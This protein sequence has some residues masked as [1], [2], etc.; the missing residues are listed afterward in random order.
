MGRRLRDAA[1]LL[2]VKVLGE[3]PAHVV[4]RWRDAERARQEH[5]KVAHVDQVLVPKVH[6]EL[7]PRQTRPRE[8]GV[9][10]MVLCVHDRKETLGER[11]GPRHPWRVPRDPVTGDEKVQPAAT[12]RGKK[13]G[14]LVTKTARKKSFLTAWAVCRTT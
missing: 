5:R 10:P 3:S 9:R 7:R 8:R 13:T 6:E 11:R 12:L 14:G 2:F 1:R 4:Q